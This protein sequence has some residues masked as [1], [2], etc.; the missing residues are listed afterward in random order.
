MADLGGCSLSLCCTC[1]FGQAAPPAPPAALGISRYNLA[2]LYRTQNSH[3]HIQLLQ[4]LLFV[5]FLK[6]CKSFM[7]IQS[8]VDEA[9]LCLCNYESNDILLSR[10]KFKARLHKLFRRGYAKCRGLNAICW[11]IIHRK[12]LFITFQLHLQNVIFLFW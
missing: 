8:A 11:S 12:T 6:G 9:T 2:S 3:L 4:I 1:C 7:S 10:P 5:F